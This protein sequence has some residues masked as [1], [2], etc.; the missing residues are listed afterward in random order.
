MSKVN[1]LFSLSIIFFLL[2]GNVACA[3]ISGISGNKINTIYY[4]PIP[5]KTV[6]FEPTLSST[7]TTGNW[8]KPNQQVDTV[9]GISVNSNIFWR[10]TYGLNNRT[11]LGLSATNNLSSINLAG[12]I[13]L[14]NSDKLKLSAMLGY[15]INLGNQQFNNSNN[16]H[17]SNSL[18]GYGIIW[19]FQLNPKNQLDVNLQIQQGFNNQNPNQVFIHAD[20]GSYFLRDDLFLLLAASYQQNISSELSSNKFTVYPGLALE[21]G[22]QFAFGLFSQHDLFGKNT[23]KTW[24]LNLVLTMV[25]N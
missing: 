6:E 11:E 13:L 8:P 1:L 9:Q 4:K 19:S 14:T 7:F 18:L 2:I 23:S 20:Y 15:G 16:K 5:V 3:Q 17:L 10:I 24:S 12:K 22:N 25:L 21:T